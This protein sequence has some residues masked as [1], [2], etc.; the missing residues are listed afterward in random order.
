MMNV[1]DNECLKNYNECMNEFKND[2]LYDC[3]IDNFNINID[4]LKYSDILNNECMNVFE[5]DFLYNNDFKNFN[6]NIDKIKNEINDF[7]PNENKLNCNNV[8][9]L[10]NINEINY[11]KIDGRPF[12]K[13]R[14]NKIAFNSLFD[15]G[16]KISVLSKII[17]RKINV[18]IKIDDSKKVSC[19]NGSELIIMG[20]V[21]LEVE[22]N[23]NIVMGEFF[24]ADEIYPTVI[25]GIDILNELK[26]KLV[27]ITNNNILSLQDKFG[28]NTPLD[29]KK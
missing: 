5:N 7:H 4:K 22:Y 1:C 26:I 24:V 23:N 12:S 25:I 6:V 13:V 8:C 9:L 11:C 28:R 3:D 19:A 2:F 17:L 21:R 16:A 14:L 29:L 15:T 18:E 27:E 10:Q 20:K